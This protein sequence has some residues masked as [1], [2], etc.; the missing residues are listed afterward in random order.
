MESN[1]D[2]E[3]YLYPATEY[4]VDRPRCQQSIKVHLSTS[5]II[6]GSIIR[7]GS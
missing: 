1:A 4:L 2:R 6:D 7:Q 3:G 5:P